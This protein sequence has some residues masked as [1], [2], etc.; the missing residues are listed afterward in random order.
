MC[1]HCNK[2][3]GYYEDEKVRVL[4]SRCGCNDHNSLEANE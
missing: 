3:I 2:T 4:Y 1:Q